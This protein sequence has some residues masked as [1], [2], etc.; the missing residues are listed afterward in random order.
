[1]AGR[2]EQYVHCAQPNQVF[3]ELFIEAYAKTS[4]RLVD[5]SVHKMG[6]E[7]QLVY[8]INNDVRSGKIEMIAPN[9]KLTIIQKPQASSKEG[10]A[11]GEKDTKP[12]GTGGASGAQSGQGGDLLPRRT[13]LQKSD[14]IKN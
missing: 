2:N 1:M 13:P 7:K 8:A 10:G 5:G 4:G 6:Q 11:K 12:S 3:G 9:Y 14:I